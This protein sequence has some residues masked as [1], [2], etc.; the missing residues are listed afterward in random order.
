MARP[1]KHDSMNVKRREISVTDAE[2]KAVKAEAKE[3]DLSVSRYLLERRTAAP[4]RVSPRTIIYQIE[5]TMDIRDQVILIA[6]RLAE[7]GAIPSHFLML[8]FIGI[9]RRLAALV[10]Q[11]GRA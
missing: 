8:E 6:D 7:N 1:R 11:A 3:A 2:W 5:T 10:R 9:E 4:A